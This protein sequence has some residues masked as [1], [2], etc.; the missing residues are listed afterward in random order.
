[1]Q[2]WAMERLAEAH[3]RDMAGVPDAVTESI[4]RHEVHEVAAD[5]PDA[6]APLLGGSWP[7]S[8][9]RSIAAGRTMHRGVSAHLG[10]WLIRAGS[11]LGG[12]SMHTSQT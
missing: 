7:A 6:V 2:T 8:A 1:M 12:A 11:R 5:P 4:S 9:G 3:R 10:D